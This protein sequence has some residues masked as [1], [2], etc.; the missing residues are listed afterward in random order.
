MTIYLV[1][2]IRLVANKYRIGNIASL[3]LIRRRATILV[4]A[5]TTQDK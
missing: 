1:K 2:Y 4:A 5:N 3:M